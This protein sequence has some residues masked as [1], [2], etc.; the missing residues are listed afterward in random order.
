MTAPQQTQAHP[1][2]TRARAW[3]LQVLYQ[4]ESATPGPAPT[5]TLAGIL[6]SRVVNPDRIPHLR[7]IVEAFSEHRATVDR[8]V[9]DALEHWTFERLGWVDRQ[10]LRLGATEL[11]YLT[12]VPPRVAIHEAVRLAERYGSD[13]SPR[14]VNGILDAIARDAA[15]TTV[16]RRRGPR[17]PSE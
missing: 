5:D 4:W 17:S 9:S 8:T 10:V 1:E 13:E 11:L 14:F 3:A 7:N 6:A 12:D 16:R 2:R 15:A